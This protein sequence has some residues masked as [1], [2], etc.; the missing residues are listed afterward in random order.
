MYSETIGIHRDEG[1]VADAHT[2]QPSTPRDPAE[3]LP[4]QEPDGKELAVGPLAIVGGC[5]HV[6]L[7][8]ALAFARKGH[9]VDLLDTSPS[10]SPWSTAAECRFT[11]T[12]PSPARRVD[13][14]RPHQG[15]H[16]CRRPRRRRRHHRHHRHAGR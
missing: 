3:P 4:L 2:V 15:D 9:A 13:P 16:R 11:K 1:R 5:G 14:R 10:A 6:G 12:T 8:L 7:P